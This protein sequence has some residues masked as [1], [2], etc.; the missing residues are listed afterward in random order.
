M[1]ARL[2]QEA[3]STLIDLEEGIVLGPAEDGGYYLIGASLPLSAAVFQ[4]IPWSGPAVLERTL[5]RARSEGID[6]RLLE[7]WH[8]IDRP[9]D[10]ASLLSGRGAPESRA[11]IESL[12][13]RPA[14]VHL[15]EQQS[16][17]KTGV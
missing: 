4:D 9:A 14:L 12:G 17:T 3:R 16:K 8:D 2:I 6:F 10:L 15:F 13:P 5:E 1:P 11:L 7:T